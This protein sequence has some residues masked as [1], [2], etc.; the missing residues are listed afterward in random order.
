[1]TDHEYGSVFYP[2][3]IDDLTTING[4]TLSV[5]GVSV[6]EDEEDDGEKVTVLM[7]TLRKVDEFLIKEDV[8]DV[9]RDAFKES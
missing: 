9:F 1:M 8:P 4:R 6:W 7:V 5:C 3:A 2:P